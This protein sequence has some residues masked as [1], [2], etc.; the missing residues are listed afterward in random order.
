MTG[1]EKLPAGLGAYFNRLPRPS[2]IL[3]LVVINLCAI[4]LAVLLALSGRPIGALAVMLVAVGNVGVLVLTLMMERRIASGRLGSEIALDGLAHGVLVEDGRGRVRVRNRIWLDLFAGHEARGR[5]W[6]RTL[7]DAVVQIAER[8]SRDGGAAVISVRDHKGDLRRIALSVQRV[9]ERPSWLTWTASERPFGTGAALSQCLE[10]AGVAWFET[11]PYGIIDSA[12]SVFMGWTGLG[13]HRLAERTLRVDRILRQDDSGRALLRIG[14][15]SDMAVEWIEGPPDAS[16]RRF[17]VLRVLAPEIETQSILEQASARFD[18]FFNEAPVGIAVLDS[19]G[20]L[21]EANAAFVAI[22][23]PERESGRVLGREFVGLIHPDDASEAAA[24]LRGDA[25]VNGRQSVEIR[26]RDVPDRVAQLF[27]AR[28]RG[29][30]E[31][32]GLTVF[33]LDTTEQKNL[34]IQFAQSQKMQAVGQLAG[35]IAH[36]FNNLL[37]AIIGFSDLLL[38]RH[39]VGDHSF[40]DINQIKQNATRAANLVR[41]LLA[42]SRQQTLRP[43]VLD[44]TEALAELSNLLRRLIGERIELRM[45]H[46]RDL[47]PVRVDPGQ[48]DQVVINLA[49]NAR[50]AMLPDGGALTIRTCNVPAADVAQL[51]H[52]L[53]P[54]ADYVLIEVADTGMGIP[55]ENFGKIFEPFFTTKEVGAGTGLGLSTVYGIIKQTGGFVFPASE[56]GKG[57]VF[58]IYLPRHAAEEVEAPR[59]RDDDGRPRDLTGKGTILLVEDEDAVR[60]FAARAL[61]NKGYTV[62]EAASG[63][64]AMGIVENHDGPID[65][66]IS[67]V[68]M[69]NMDGPTLIKEARRVRGDMKII[70]IS[71]YAE[72]AFRKNLDREETFRFLPKPFSLKQLAGTVKE[73]MG[74]G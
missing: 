57:A 25:A 36:D 52:A 50:D 55:K 38:V 46:G 2:A 62:L 17:S 64:V 24:V 58:R 16:G 61:R 13:S 54:Q 69:P 74:R 42:F 53:M 21:E 35:G 68:V 8:L 60:V 37:T 72:D 32:G 67:D 12:S 70:F 51:G 19:G 71:G 7:P 22:A 27:V 1:R 11:D 30:R 44:I 48:F 49:V 65:L 14:E 31:G 43:K 63:D 45:I 40:G 10:L 4:L 56:P 34:E 23:S 5:N 41:Q 3:T 59:E 33:L 28:T 20:R 26:F 73:E 9:P 39:S 29:G 66:L 18:R 47:G 15:G 6:Y